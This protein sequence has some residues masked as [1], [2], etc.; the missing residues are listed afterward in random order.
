L[1][2]KSRQVSLNRLFSGLNFR[3]EN[4]TELKKQTGPVTGF[5]AEQGTLSCLKPVRDPVSC[6]LTLLSSCLNN[7]P[8]KSPSRE[9]CLDLKF[10]NKKPVCQ[11]VFADRLPKPSVNEDLSN[12]FFNLQKNT[13]AT[14]HEAAKEREESGNA[15]EGEAENKEE[16]VNGK[17]E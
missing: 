5:A 14:R 1:S 15:K 12:F 9:T 4:R 7:S 8:E 10:W 13:R 16:D 11:P 6:R 17:T 2:S 3:Q